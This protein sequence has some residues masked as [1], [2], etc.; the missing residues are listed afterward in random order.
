MHI[1]KSK[2]IAVTNSTGRTRHYYTVPLF[3]GQANDPESI[4]QLMSHGSGRYRQ[5]AR[6]L[7]E[8]EDALKEKRPMD[9]SRYRI[10]YRLVELGRGEKYFR[11]DNMP[12][13][14]TAMPKVADQICKW[15]RQGCM[16]AVPA[17]KTL[18]EKYPDY[19][20]T[21]DLVIEESKVFTRLY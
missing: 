16:T 15:I 18:S 12:Y 4:L 10:G 11:R 3:A 19:S 1:P 2:A 14:D 21:N 7:D 5:Q 8:Q 17:G 6:A 13:S 9:L 20:I